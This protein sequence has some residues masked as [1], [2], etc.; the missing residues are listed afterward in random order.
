M[1]TY[2]LYSLSTGL[3]DKGTVTVQDDLQ[4]AANIPAGHGIAEGNFSAREWRFD[5]VTGLVA[6]YTP[7]PPSTDMIAGQARS[8]RDALLRA[9]DWRVIRATDTGEPMAPDWQ[10][11]RTALRNVTLQPSFPSVIDWPAAPT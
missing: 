9:T 6:P 5:L 4:L 10:A 8:H 2:T 11:Y 1:K 7:P 3:M